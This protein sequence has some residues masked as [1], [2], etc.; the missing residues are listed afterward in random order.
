[1]KRSSKIIVTSC[2]AFLLVAIIAIATITTSKRAKAE[3]VDKSKRYTLNANT[4]FDF[5]GFATT[6]QYFLQDI[7]S[8]TLLFRINNNDYLDDNNT[9]YTFAISISKGYTT[10]HYTL[11]IHS[12]NNQT[13]TINQAGYS[14]DYYYD[15]E[16]YILDFVPA[17]DDDPDTAQLY[18][19]SLLNQGFYIVEG[20]SLPDNQISSDDL[21]P[22]SI[23]YYAFKS[24][25]FL[26]SYNQGDGYQ[27]GYNDGYKVGYDDGKEQG[28]KNGFPEGRYVGYEEG[29]REGYQ[30]GLNDGNTAF[31]TFGNVLTT[32]WNSAT[33]F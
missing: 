18:V 7:D 23:T 27:Q 22:G 26:T 20:L 16:M 11:R 21:E 25:L 12:Y 29:H 5:S 1:M 19:T 9:F 31:N 3:F 30:E 17:F 32:A 13:H 14:F 2:L 6:T 8:N 10:N 28:Y 15:Y 24:E 4:L 33:S